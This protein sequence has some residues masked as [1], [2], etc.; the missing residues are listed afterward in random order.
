LESFKT[1]SGYFFFLVAFLP[2]LAPFLAA[3]FFFFAT[4][5]PPYR[6]NLVCVLPLAPGSESGKDASHKPFEPVNHDKLE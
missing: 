2:F 1:K 5:N 4:R 6:S 3:F